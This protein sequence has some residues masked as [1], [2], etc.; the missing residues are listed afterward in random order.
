MAKRTDNSQPRSMLMRLARATTPV[1][2]T[3]INK[4]RADSLIRNNYND[5]DHGA[6]T[7]AAARRHDDEGTRQPYAAKLGKARPA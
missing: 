3:K 1:R 7:H 4:A 6:R 2:T 5:G